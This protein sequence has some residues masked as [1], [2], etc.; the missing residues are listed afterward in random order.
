[1]KK[2]SVLQIADENWQ[3]QYEIPSNIKW[4]FV[5]P[6]DI[7]SLLPEDIGILN[8]EVEAENGKK[9]K[10]KVDK[11]FDVVLVDTAEYLEYVTILDQKIQVYR[12]FYHER[13]QITTK[14]LERF[15]L[16]KKAVKTNF[17]NPEQMLHIF[18]RGFFSKQNGTKLSVNH[19]VAAPS[20][21]GQVSYEGT[22]YLRLCGRYGEDY[23]TIATYQHNVFL[24]GEM[25]L[26]LW[27]EFRVSEGCSIRYVVKGFPAGNSPMQEWIYDETSFDRSLTIDV[28]DSYYLSI[29][30]QA[31]G[32]GIVKLGPCHYRDSH[33][34]YGDLLVGGKRI[35]DKNREELIY[36]FHPGDLK[37]PLNIYFSGYRPAE[38]FEGYWMMNN[39]GSP[40]LLVGDPR[41]EGGAF[42][43]GSE[44]LEQKLLQV[45]HNCLDE[46]GFTKKQ[47]TLS[48]L[49]MGTFG[50]LYYSSKL[51]PHAVIVGKPL[52]NLGDMAENESTIRPGGFPT[53]LDLVYRT[54]GELSSEATA[55]L[56]ERFWTAFESADFS[57]TKFIISFMYQDDYDMSAYPDMLDELGQR[58][59][60]VSVI[61]KGLT[62]RHNDDTQGIVE[63]FFNQ[64]KTLLMN[65]FEREFKS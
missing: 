52:V 24:S 54:I 49:S 30:I 2:I 32:Q 41:S 36:F 5:K 27:P 51:E 3:E 14:T 19:L 48:G 7:V 28:N 11:P 8:R 6:E 17:E 4:T 57:R 40:F 44:E 53:S 29:S 45:V 58:D 20:F 12:L 15:L 50:A 43:L 59:Y 25:P 26:D 1:M 38:G 10:K 33:L 56:N 46:L 39:L 60:R 16:R 37:P 64:Y 42:Y 21:E 61:S 34:G 18:S 47:L 23:Q 9:K 35:S 65:S 55:Q 63:W 62:G 22:N 31:K 13:C